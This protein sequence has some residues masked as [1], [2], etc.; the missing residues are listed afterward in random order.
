M[1]VLALRARAF[2]QISSS[3]RPRKNYLPAKWNGSAPVRKVTF[4]PPGKYWRNQSYE[5]KQSRPFP[6]GSQRNFWRKHK[7]KW[8]S[9][10]KA[11]GKIW[12]GKNRLIVSGLEQIWTGRWRLIF[13]ST[14][15]NLKRGNVFRSK[16]QIP[17]RLSEKQKRA[18]LHW[19]EPAKKCTWVVPLKN[20][21]LT[22]KKNL[23]NPIVS[24]CTALGE[25]L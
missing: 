12:G 6:E 4:A 13:S 8:T 18:H 14:W 9:T 15:A 10:F 19:N 21:S 1:K 2:I 5:K 11:P 23:I 17:W 25:V 7:L 22:T 24:F 20:Q 16:W 3:I